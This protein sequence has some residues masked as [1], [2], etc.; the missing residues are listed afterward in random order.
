MKNVALI[1]GASSGIGKELAR[2]HAEQGGDLVIVARSKEKLEALKSELESNHG[3]QVKIIAKDLTVSNAPREIYDEVSNTGIEV[4][5]LINNAGFGGRG[6]FYERSW[7]QD[8]AM[9]DLNVVALTALTRH[10]LPGFV[11]R[12]QGRILNVSSTASFMPGPLQAVYYATKAYVTFFG[13]AIAEELHDTNIT[14]TTLMP[15]ATETEFAKVSGMDKTDLFD[16]TVS[17]RSVAKDGY[18]GMLNGKLDVV[19]GLRTNQKLMMKMIPFMPKK[20]LLKQ[21]RK[22]Q[23]AN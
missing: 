13:N 3:V 20:M 16:K 4:E 21:I 17:A 6:K 15:G 7:E 23:E 2:I 18:D 1:T 12:N 8:L 14:V 19:S 11:S 9:I 10:F 5:Y 22:L